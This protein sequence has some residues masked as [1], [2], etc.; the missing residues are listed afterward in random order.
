MT[1]LRNT[2]ITELYTDICWFFK[3]KPEAEIQSWQCSK[4]LQSTLTWHPLN[5]YSEQCFSGLV[6]VI[7]DTITLGQL[8]LSSHQQLTMTVSLWHQ[9]VQLDTTDTTQIGYY[10]SIS[11]HMKIYWRSL[12]N[13]IWVDTRA[14]DTGQP[15]QAQVKTLVH[16]GAAP[17]W[18]RVPAIVV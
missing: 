1:T 7:S 9:W 15:S 10:I 2:H 14:L 4:L 6:F 5:I 11:C 18:S 17:G 13:S 3:M 16:G 8:L 12:H